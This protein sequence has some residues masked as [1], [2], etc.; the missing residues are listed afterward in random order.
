M[1]CFWIAHKSGEE[2]QYSGIVRAEYSIAGMEQ[3]VEG[4]DIFT[5]KFPT[6]SNLYLFSD[7]CT[8]SID[9]NDISS[10]SVTKEAE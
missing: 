8:S 1:Y 2:S 5:H 9:G 6:T 10:I 3:V 4:D 7:D